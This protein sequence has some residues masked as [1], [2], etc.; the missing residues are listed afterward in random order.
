MNH[1]R[2]SMAAHHRGMLM[3]NLPR[4]AAAVCAWRQFPA[5]AQAPLSPAAPAACGSRTALRAHSTQIP[6]IWKQEAVLQRQTDVESHEPQNHPWMEGLALEPTTFLPEERVLTF[7]S[8]SIGAGRLHDVARDWKYLPT[9]MHPQGMEVVLQSHLF[10]GYAR[11]INALATIH[12]VGVDQ[13]EGG[14]GW[15]ME[16]YSLEKWHADG[17]VACQEIYGRAYDKLRKRMGDM[18]PVLDKMMIENGYGESV[19][20]RTRLRGACISLRGSATIVCIGPKP[21]ALT[22]DP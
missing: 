11:A 2:G 18:H 16:E 12:R 8:A 19:E 22:P 17:E 7:L 14:E 20:S 13:G 5:A 3:R 4:S 21:W 1:C 10:A 6:S 15:R 9:S